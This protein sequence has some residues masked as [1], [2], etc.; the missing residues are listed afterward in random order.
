MANELVHDERRQ[1]KPLVHAGSDQTLRRPCASGTRQI[2]YHHGN[3]TQRIGDWGSKHFSAVRQRWLFL[4]PNTG[5]GWR[6]FSTGI[7]QFR[8]MDVARGRLLLSGCEFDVP[9]WSGGLGSAA[10]TSTLYPTG[11][12]AIP[13]GAGLS[14]PAGSLDFRLQEK[15]QTGAASSRSRRNANSAKPGAGI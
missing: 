10:T 4:R 3:S 7:V 13:N 5:R 1:R 12:R 14:Q 9:C 11:C 8:K 6:G 2:Q 15:G